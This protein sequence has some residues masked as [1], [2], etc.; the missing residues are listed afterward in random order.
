MNRNLIELVEV[1][2]LDADG[3]PSSG[4]FAM[5]TAPVG[6]GGSFGIQS[7]EVGRTPMS[8]LMANH[9]VR[10]EL[11]EPAHF[12]DSSAPRAEERHEQAAG[13]PRAE[14]ERAWRP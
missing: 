3:D 2:G 4:G 5:E 10:H 14:G 13:V 8:F 6:V 12:G 1:L 7:S 11:Q 9:V